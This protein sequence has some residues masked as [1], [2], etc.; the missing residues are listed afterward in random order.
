[1]LERI[2]DSVQY[3]ADR[4]RGTLHTM[5]TQAEIDFDMWMSM[6]RARRDE[7]VRILINRRYGRFYASAENAF[8][9]SLVTILYA[10]FERRD[11]TVNFSSLRRTIPKDADP[12]VLDEIGRQYDE[13][14]K[15]WIRIGIIRNEVVGHQTLERLREESHEVAGLT[16]QDLKS[17]I[18]LCQDLLFQI[19]SKFHDAHVVFNL[20]GAETFEKL[21]EDLRSNNSLQA[22]R[23]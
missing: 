9:N 5:L 2:G 14:K 18:S 1:M 6:R 13:I 8:F 10:V 16:I 11:D 22:R 20:K 17:M 12:K 4:I 23:P 15:I 21:I 19:A 7:E 3:D